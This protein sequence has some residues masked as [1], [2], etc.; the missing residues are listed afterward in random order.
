MYCYLYF[1]QEIED[2][3]NQYLKLF[4]SYE[5]KKNFLQK[6][7]NKKKKLLEIINFKEEKNDYEKIKIIDK[8][9]LYKFYK[10]NKMFNNDTLNNEYKNNIHNMLVSNI[11][12]KAF[13]KFSIYHKF[14]NPFK[15]ENKEF[16]EQINR[17][18]FYIYFP[19]SR[20]NRLSS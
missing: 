10:D 7:L 18:K 20:I 14:N 15:E 9:I 2:T 1:P 12:N 4:E 16:I 8:K 17:V 19:L 6:K 13:D 3:N 5:E 11:T